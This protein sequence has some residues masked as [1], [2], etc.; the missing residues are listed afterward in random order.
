MLVLPE[1]DCLTATGLTVY[2]PLFPEGAH[3]YD[4]WAAI[5]FTDH[6]GGV[7]MLGFCDVEP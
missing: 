7:Q 2:V 1:S 5:P 6:P 4:R 3:Y